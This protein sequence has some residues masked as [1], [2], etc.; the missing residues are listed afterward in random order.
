MGTSGDS[1][2]ESQIRDALAHLYDYAYLQRHPLATRLV[3]VEAAATRTRGQELRRILLDAI[4][5][6]NP[7]D[8]VPIRAPERRPYAILFGL[9]VEGR[10]QPEV[11]D[12]LGIGGRQLRRDRAEALAALASVVRDRY[13]VADAPAAAEEPVRLESERLA[14]QREP[15]DLGEL[16]RG[17][18]PLLE[19]MARERGVSLVSRVGPGL[20]LLSGNRTLLRQILLSLASQTLTTFPLTCLSFEAQQAA[21]MIGVGLRLA[22]REGHRPAPELET[23]SVE[24][25]VTALG[26]SLRREAT[27]GGQETVWVLL[28]L[29]DETVVLVIDDNEALFTLFQRYVA[30]QPY[31]LHHA[32]NA[33]EALARV[34]GE[35]PGVITLDLMMPGRDGWDILQALRAEPVSARIPVIV[36][37]VLEEPELALSLGAQLCLKKPVGQ[38]ELLRALA[39][40]KTRAWAG[41]GCRGAPAR[42]STPPSPSGSPAPA[43]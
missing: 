25:L 39:E 31:R 22:Y 16:V 43:G 2:L 5:A 28:P 17:L 23:R 7:G 12:G 4:E 38:A 27:H 15:V 35:A 41:E 19:G 14:Q 26:G 11:A 8:N 21:A 6:L 10:S 29:Q 18:L 42:S 3:P 36:C 13:R 24:A 34:R 1:S 9:Y 30:G 37:S 20:P 32:A 33:G 40:A